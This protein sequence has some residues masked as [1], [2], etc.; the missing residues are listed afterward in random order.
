MIVEPAGVTPAFVAALSVGCYH[1]SQ[2]RLMIRTVWIGRLSTTGT[3]V[4][5]FKVSARSPSPAI[6]SRR[7][8]C[9]ARAAVMAAS[10]NI[11]ASAILRIIN[12]N[13]IKTM[14]PADITTSK[15]TSR[16]QSDRWALT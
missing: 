13:A 5:K 2:S 1:R 14:L 11:A 16:A 12:G 15:R 3:D 8:I 7:T 10:M 9:V 6:R 4:V